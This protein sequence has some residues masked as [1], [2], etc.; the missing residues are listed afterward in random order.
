[1][2]GVGGSGGTDLQGQAPLGGDGIHGDDVAG[3]A[4]RRGHDGAEAD[5]RRRR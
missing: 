3:T 1:M 5:P 4:Q 2:V